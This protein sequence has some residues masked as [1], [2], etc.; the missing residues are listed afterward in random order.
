[1]ENIMPRPR[2]PGLTENELEVMQ[3]LWRQAPLMVS[4]LLNYL[5]RK[6]IPA[7]TS[8]LTLVQTMEKKGY[9][10]HQKSG[11]AFAY[12]PVLKQEKFLI[13]EVKRVAKRLFRGS[14]GKLVL[15]L[16]ENEQLTQTEIEALKQLL[17]DEK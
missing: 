10:R 6:P 14:P 11:K 9:I 1:M 5:Q 8:L 13:S 16:V 17:R 3:I 2:Q 7:Y 15:N 12:L 4:E